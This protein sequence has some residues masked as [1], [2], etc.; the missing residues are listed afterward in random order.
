MLVDGGKDSFTDAI[1]DL[2]EVLSKG[3][4]EGLRQ[5]CNTR[6]VFQGHLWWRYLW[7]L[8]LGWQEHK[9]CWW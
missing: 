4:L 9:T 2:V 1:N 6:G 7:Q 3:K 5:V 8:F